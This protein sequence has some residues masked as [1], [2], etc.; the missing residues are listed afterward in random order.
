MLVS[1]QIAARGVARTDTEPTVTIVDAGKTSIIKIAS[2]TGAAE[3][4]LVTPSGEVYKPEDGVTDPSAALSDKAFFKKNPSAHEGFWAL[5]SPVAGTYKLVIRNLAELGNIQTEL[6]VQNTKPE[7]KLTAPVVDAYVNPG[8]KVTISWEDKDPDSN[9]KISLYYDTDDKGVDGGLIIDGI[10]EDSA[11][12][13]YEWTAPDNLHGGFHIYAIID[14]GALGADPVYSTGKIIFPDA[15]GPTTPQNV[16][17]TAADGSATVAW[18][19]NSA[20]EK[21]AAYRIHIREYGSDTENVVVVYEDITS[22]TFENLGNGVTYEIA[23]SAANEDGQEGKLGAWQ[24]ITPSGLSMNGPPDLSI[25]GEMQA[26]V[27]GSQASLDVI[28]KNSSNYTAHSYTFSC[29]LDQEDDAHLL[30]K[31]I[32][33]DLLGNSTATHNFSFDVLNLPQPIEGKVICRI[34]NVTLTE[35]N[36]RNNAMLN[37]TALRSLVSA[38][39]NPVANNDTATTQQNTPVT[40]GN[41]LANDTDAD[42]DILT[43]SAADATSVKG[44][45]VVNNGNGTFTYTPKA[46]FSGTD[47]FTYTVSDGKGGV[48]TASVIITVVGTSTPIAYSSPVGN[49]DFANTTEGKPVT[50]ANVLANDTDPNNRKLTA[51]STSKTSLYGGTVVDNGNATFTYTPKSGFTGKDYFTYWIKNDEGNSM[52]GLVTVVVSPASDSPSVNS[53]LETAKTTSDS[54]STNQGGGGSIDWLAGM[55]LLWGL[56]RKYWRKHKQ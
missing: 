46:G 23:V 1:N 6:L 51:S 45:A 12:N 54:G 15:P 10:E 21:V 41:V 35:L 49:D 43:I 56:T 53:K 55:F 37:S 52:L 25:D 11:T 31:I 5:R 22:Y 20:A 2:D 33:K 39:I 17:L 4:E 14:D 44:G 8:E 32:G 34:S 16:I 9:A 24:A 13:S 50:T 28:V 7:I 48:A 30:T 27:N 42:S 47:T 38:N 18:T 3:F 36:E 40:T 19:L 29:W 26:T